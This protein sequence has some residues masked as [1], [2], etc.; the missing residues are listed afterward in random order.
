MTL[1]SDARVARYS[2]DFLV[3]FRSRCT[4]PPPR[5]AIEPAT[6]DLLSLSTAAAAA[7][8]SRQPPRAF[9][10][11]RSTSSAPAQAAKLHKASSAYKVGATS[12]DEERAQKTLKSLLNKISPQTF[13]VLAARIV[14]TIL[15]REQA[16]TLSGFIA[17]I[18]DKALSEPSFSEMYA[19][20]V[21]ALSPALPRLTDD[22]GELVDFRRTLVNAC[23]SEFE[24]D[25][26]ASRDDLPARRRMLGNIVFIGHLYRFGVLT[27][28]VMHRCVSQLL[29]DSQ[30]T[31]RP[32]DVQCLCTLMTIA[33]KA[34]DASTKSVMR[35]PRAPVSTA[36][37]MHEC[38]ARIETL[39]SH[40]SL[41]SRHRFM[42]KDLIDLREA[43]R[44][45][46]RRQ[47]EGPTTILNGS[48][49]NDA[50]CFR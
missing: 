45:V 24:R 6:W 10:P 49:K 46:P 35:P 9:P 1:M 4:T 39:S 25:A 50:G 5:S 42:L 37:V 48:S 47:T 15:E 2:T 19:G 33:G 18:F 28:A 30:Q 44:W 40:P 26:P 43:R 12:T 27:D 13:D 3:S 23:Q 11:G 34:M 14:S 16:Q 29:Q 7:P 22:T 41:D 20:L 31:P 32:E 36:S 38:F 8:R 21:V 17:Q